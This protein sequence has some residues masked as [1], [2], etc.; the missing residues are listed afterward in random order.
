[1]QFDGVS[2]ESIPLKSV[3]AVTTPKGSAEADVTADQIWVYNDGAWTKY[4]F[5]VKRGA[6]NIWC[7]AGTTTEI[8]DDIVLT[9]GQSF[10]FVRS[11]AATEPCQL[12]L[13]GSVVPLSSIK[14]YDITPGSTTAM[15]FPWPQ[16]MK[17]KDFTAFNPDPKGS[18]EADVTADQIWVYNDGAWTKYY[19]YVKR[20]AGNIWCLAGTTTEISDDIVIA[21]G[22]AFYFVRST[23]AAGNVTISFKR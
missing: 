6:G 2:G 1:M 8:S 16:N 22:S 21:P 15:A 10:Y 13:S 5:Y 17:I 20:G 12:T 4:Y 9:S 7:L 23:A 14:T 11:T 19:F 18:A 3:V